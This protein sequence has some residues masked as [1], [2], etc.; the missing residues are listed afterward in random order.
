M[1][2]GNGMIAKQFIKR[3][4]SYKEFCV[5]ASGVSYANCNSQVEFERELKLLN[6]QIKNHNKLIYFSSFHVI[7]DTLEYNSYTNHKKNMETYII[8]NFEDYLIIRLPNV[9]GKG[10]NKHTLFSLLYYNLMSGKEMTIHTNAYRYLIDVSDVEY[11]VNIIK[12]NKVK[13]CNMLF[14][15]PI[16]IIKIADMFESI[17][18]KKYK[19][20][21]IKKG[22]GRYIINTDYFNKVL[23]EIK[24]SYDETTYL[25]DMIK[26]YYL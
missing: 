1:I 7:I 5:F 22:E 26:K 10:G 18:G 3:K 9:I 23:S 2:V 15:D 8:N 14:D 20:K 16:S 25:S 11:F 6:D 19:R 24:Y 13:V 4:E 17:V 21:Y 12:D